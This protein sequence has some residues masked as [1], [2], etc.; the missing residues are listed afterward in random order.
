MNALKL[1]LASF[2]MLFSVYACDDDGDS[3]FDGFDGGAAVSQAGETPSE[4]CH[5]VESMTFCGGNPDGDWTLSEVCLKDASA[6][7]NLLPCSVDLSERFE[8]VA[9]LK[10]QEQH[11]TFTGKSYSYDQMV[12]G[13][14]CFEKGG[15]SCAQFSQYTTE[16]E[17]SPY[18][19]CS[20]SNARCVCES[21][22]LMEFNDQGTLEIEGENISFHTENEKDPHSVLSNGKFCV[23]EN[24]M[25][26]QSIF[27]PTYIFTK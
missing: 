18:Q 7:E 11:Y 12:L 22:E 6:F 27:G 4:S 15:G 9:E 21:T 10:I 20:G 14:D 16:T 26:W 3:K 17:N 13:A 23:Q 24:R 8:I 19:S 1:G 25:I 5:S 2:T